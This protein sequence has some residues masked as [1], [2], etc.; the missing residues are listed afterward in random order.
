LDPAQEAESVLRKL[1]QRGD[2]IKHIHRGLA[3]AGTSAPRIVL[4]VRPDLAIAHQIHASAATRL[5][6]AS[7]PGSPR[8]AI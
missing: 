2:I 6:V 5:D 7:S 8:C 1:S 4:A 3:S